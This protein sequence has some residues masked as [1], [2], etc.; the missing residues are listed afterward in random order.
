M[1]RLFIKIRDFDILDGIPLFLVPIVII[2]LF[3]YVGLV[4]YINSVALGWLVGIP[5]FFAGLLYYGAITKVTVKEGTKSYGLFDPKLQ[6][7][8]VWLNQIVI[9][10][11]LVTASGFGAVGY[12]FVMLV[13]IP[14]L[15][16][17]MQTVLSREVT[18]VEKD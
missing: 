4:V 1:K 10:Y 15:Y 11:W 9:C 3:A 16:L 17:S 8:L 12:I 7:A 13:V 18:N 6:M 5:S 14:A 2:A